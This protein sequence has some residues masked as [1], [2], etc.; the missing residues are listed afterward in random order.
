MYWAAIGCLAVAAALGIRLAIGH[1]K[2][3]PLPSAVAYT[4]GLFAAAGLLLLV[5]LAVRGLLVGL[6]TVALIVFIGAALGG[7]TIFATPSND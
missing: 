1:S 4:H 5:I 3:K 2:D 6:G 7:A